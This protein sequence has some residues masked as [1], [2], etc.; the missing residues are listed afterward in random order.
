MWARELGVSLLPFDPILP[1]Q[2][3][4][5]NAMKNHKILKG[6][7]HN[8]IDKLLFNQASVV[9]TYL[10]A[11]AL[12]D[13]HSNGM[14]FVLESEARAH[15]AA[16]EAARQAEASAPRASVSY[17]ADYYPDY[18]LLT[19]LGQKPKLGGVRVFQR[20]YIHVHT[21]HSSC[22]C[23]HFFIVLSMLNLFFLL[24]SCVFEKL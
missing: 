14:Y 23:P 5:F 2:Y 22:R 15:N 24:S 9:Y 20:H 10:H 21:F 18:W 6:D 8:F 12:F 11:P 16:V 13:Y 7:I 3:F 4:D 17:H 19:K 1:T